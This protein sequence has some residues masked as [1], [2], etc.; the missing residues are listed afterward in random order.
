MNM[1]D[2]VI[3]RIL[4]TTHY[5]QGDKWKIY[6][7][8]DFA[9]PLEDS[10]EGITH[11]LCSLEWEDHR[12]LYDWFVKNC[13]MPH[14]PRQIEFARLSLE[15]TVMSKRFLK[16]FVDRGLVTG[17]DDPRM[18]TIKGLKRKGYTK[19]AIKSFIFNTGLSKVNTT[20]EN[21]MLEAE[22]RND[23]QNKAYAFMAIKEPLKVIIL[24]YEPDK[25]E[26]LEAPNNVNNPALGTRLIPFTRE[27]YIEKSDF[28]VIKPEKSWKRL[29]LGGEVRLFHAYFIKCVDVIYNEQKEINEIHC[30]YD[31]ETKSGSG[32][33]QRKPDGTIHF[34]SSII[35]TPCVF[36]V[37]DSLI[38]STVKGDYCA[39]FNENSLI[40]FNGFTEYLTSESLKISHFQF[41]RDGF[42]CFDKL[43]LPSNI[44]FNQSVSLK[45]KVK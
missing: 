40:T 1:R 4:N 7:M 10:I 42:Y 36:N 9:H 43:S 11:S 20:I 37:F 45:S 27:L 2:P 38:N 22:L 30:I 33:N 26:Y 31:V 23:L 25:I 17:W 24:N 16:E 28:A 5:R 18:P 19:E 44:V 34:V 35:N 29:T 41:I 13:E 8:Y 12:P 15:N 21:N 6:P 39:Q 14:T 3:Y 32:F